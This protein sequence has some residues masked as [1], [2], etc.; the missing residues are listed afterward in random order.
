MLKL[1]LPLTVSFLVLAVGPVAATTINQFNTP[2]V[3][4]FDTLALS[5]TTNS[6]LPVGWSFA[7]SGTGANTTYAA[8]T[9]SSSTGNTYS[10]GA[11]ASTE[12]AFGTLRTTSL[13]SALGTEV[14]NATGSTLTSLAIAY[15]GEQ[16]RLGATGRVDRLSFAYSLDATS[17]VTG[18][19]FDVVALDFVAPISTGATGA[20]DGNSAANQSALSHTITGLNLAPAS[21]VWLRWS[22]YV[23]AG[24]NDGLA[25]DQV[26]ISALSALTPQPPTATVPDGMPSGFLIVLLLG[27]LRAGA[28]RRSSGLSG[29]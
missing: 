24:S 26:S 16:W 20:L 8:G 28:V 23:A 29:S 5:G 19:W 13:L 2:V 22:D 7:E 11:T 21:T 15:V 3:Q 6:A 4:D 12:R 9:G 27:L 17:L 25:I 1:S 14:T 10:F 18:S